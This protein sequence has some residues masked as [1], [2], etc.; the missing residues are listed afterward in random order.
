MRQP[1]A[2]SSQWGVT[3][4]FA[5]KGAIPRVMT[6][7]R[8]FPARVAGISSDSWVINIVR[9][10]THP[11]H[12]RGGFTPVYF[13]CPRK[14]GGGGDQSSIWVHWTNSNHSI[15]QMETFLS[16]IHAIQPKWVCSID[17]PDAYFYIAVHLIYKKFLR[18]TLSQSLSISSYAFRIGNSS[19]S[20]HTTA[21]SSMFN[22]SFFKMHIAFVDSNRH[23][24]ADD[25][26]IKPKFQTLVCISTRYRNWSRL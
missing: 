6:R 7:D 26:G 1:Q 23:P 9:A 13:L 18:F 16:I 11:L 21:P 8:Q 24:Q 25:L 2:P 17:L 14:V 5:S 10:C 15:L 12:E 20:V 22:D 19:I 4:F 3:P